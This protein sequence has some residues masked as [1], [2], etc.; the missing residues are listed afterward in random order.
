MTKT[1]RR[2]LAA[3]FVLSI[4]GIAVVA[5]DERIT[6]GLIRRLA[7]RGDGVFEVKPYLQ[8]GD[9]TGPGIA[10]KESLV[11]LWQ[12]ADRE[13][14]W[15]VEVAAQAS[16]P[17]QTAEP[18]SVKRIALD[19]LAP[20]RLY[21]ASL[22]NLTPGAEFVYRVRRAGAIAFESRGRARKPP[23]QPQRFVVFGDC[24]AGTWG[25]GAIAYQTHLARPDY[26]VVTGDIV[27]MRGRVSEYLDH[28][29]PVYNSERA[30]RTWG[31]PL[32]RSTLLFTASGNHDLIERD[33]DLHPDGLAFFY[34]WALPLNGPLASPGTHGFPALKGT[35]ARQRAFTDGAGPAYPRM[36]NYSFDYGDVHWTILD[37][38]PYADWTDPL[39]RDW[40][41][42]DL[43]S[44]QHAAWRIV[45]F[46]HPAFSSSKAHAEDQH[47]R[48]LAET[49]ETHDVDLVFTGHVHNY[50]RTHPLRFVART[51]T[52]TS[53][54]YGPGGQVDGRWMLDISYDGS[55]R[56]RPDG[57]IYIVTGAGGARLY[58]PE[59]TDNPRSWQPFTARFVSNVHSMSVVDVGDGHLIVRQVS[60]SG[61][62]ID[63]FQLTR[64]AGSSSP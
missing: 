26:V 14:A 50:Q 61:D 37:S 64:N 32:L 5:F 21:R 15:S 49:F 62:E 46:H 28:F 18:P 20:L 35:P 36:A 31:A 44:A 29:F 33:L 53:S 10:A 25:Q 59:Q 11:V 24:A 43:A 41:D 30:G 12:T 2:R 54:P 7:A 60:A 58:D 47:M 17:W 63:R 51:R 48:V 4:V 6:P 42:A 38:N 57:I 52:E 45:A 13:A 34:Y 19:G 56:T 39:L 40:L 22:K 27:Y 3:L 9:P 1:T 23:G 16:G 55:D 8:L